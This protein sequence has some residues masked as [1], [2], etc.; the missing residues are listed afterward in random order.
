MSDLTQMYISEPRLSSADDTLAEALIVRA[1]SIFPRLETRDEISNVLMKL[2]SFAQIRLLALPVRRDLQDLAA[3]S[4]RDLGNCIN[5]NE[6]D[7]AVGM[8]A[9]R[10]VQTVFSYGNQED[11]AGAI[12]IGFKTFC[13]RIKVN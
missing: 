6:R 5:G 10:V 1:P 9:L 12:A 13:Q 8:A 7:H 4:L 2:I 11:L 3:Q